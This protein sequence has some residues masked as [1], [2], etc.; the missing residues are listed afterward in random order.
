MMMLPASCIVIVRRKGIPVESYDGLI[1][2][3]ARAATETSSFRLLSTASKGLGTFNFYVQSA[4]Q[5][6]MMVLDDDDKFT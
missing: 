1:G 5:G 3:A 2:D 4:L 6:L